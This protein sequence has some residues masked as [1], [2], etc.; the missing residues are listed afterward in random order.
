MKIT[1]KNPYVNLDAQTK[2]VKDNK[3]I[4]APLRQT[5]TEVSKG[6]KVVLSPEAKKIQETK[7]L[8]GS[9]PDIREEKVAQIK[10][11][12]ENGTYRI[13]EE[14]L[15]VKMIKESLLNELL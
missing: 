12:I 10:A 7:E 15:A 8:M 6:D 2:N 1:G 13:K 11:Q 4:G 14:E 5:S 9:I 3:K